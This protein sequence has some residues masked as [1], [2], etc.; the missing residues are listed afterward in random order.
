[1]NTSPME[2]LT[3]FQRDLLCV[4]AGLDDPSGLAIKSHLEEYYETAVYHG[5][6]YPNLDILVDQR[7]IKKEAM[8]KRTNVYLL[9]DNGKQELSMRRK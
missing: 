9:T 3:G 7:L 1:M 6:L 4:I 8:D 5:R 2:D